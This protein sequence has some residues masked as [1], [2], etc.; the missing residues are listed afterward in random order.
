[1]T[2]HVRPISPDNP[3]R[4]LTAALSERKDAAAG[5]PAKITVKRRRGYEHLVLSFVIRHAGKAA[6]VA[7]STKMKQYA[8]PLPGSSFPFCD[9]PG[10][11][12]HRRMDLRPYGPGR[13]VCGESDPHRQSG[14]AGPAFVYAA[15]ARAFHDRR[16][17]TDVV[18][19]LFCA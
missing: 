18:C 8:P 12:A 16:G 1:M 11:G 3:D 4:C 17:C 6:W 14:N 7:R 10:C 2:N 13:P 19:Q 9:S 15:A 5:E